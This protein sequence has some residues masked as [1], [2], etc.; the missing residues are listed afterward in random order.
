MKTLKDF[1]SETPADKKDDVAELREMMLHTTKLVLEFMDE[2]RLKGDAHQNRVDLLEQL[3]DTNVKSIELL[4]KT[5]R[6]R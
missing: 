3:V 4:E 2:M 5:T 1:L 6:G